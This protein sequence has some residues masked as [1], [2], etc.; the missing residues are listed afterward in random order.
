MLVGITSL[1]ADGETVMSQGQYHGR[2]IS[3]DPKAGFKVECEGKW[4]GHITGLPPHIS[5]FERAK[6]GTYT[7][8]STGETVEDPD[9]V[10]SWTVVEPA[11]P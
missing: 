11:A 3:A 5:V 2:I 6:P 1:K 10:A 7:L 8:R 4:K 9:L